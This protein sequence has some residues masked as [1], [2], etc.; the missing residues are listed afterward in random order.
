M[1]ESTSGGL[2]REL[3]GKQDLT[4]EHYE[5]LEGYADGRTK[6]TGGRVQDPPARRARLHDSRPRSPR[7]K[8]QAPD[9]DVAMK[10]A[11][12]VV[13][14]DGLMVRTEEASYVN[15][16]GV[17][18]APG[19]VAFERGRMRGTA[20]GMTYDKTRDVLSLLDRVV[21]RE[22]AGRERRGAPRHRGRRPRASR[23]PT[24]T[25]ASNAA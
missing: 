3:G 1:V 2:V 15:S 10:G 5:K 8:G 4:I 6:I 17:V 14:S 25:C 24:S 9:V 16:E 18:R 20:V 21:I 12:E 13:A 7:F 19:A 22:R 11:V 23:A